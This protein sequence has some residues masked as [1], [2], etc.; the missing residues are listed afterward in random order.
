MRQRVTIM[1]RRETML[2]EENWME[3]IMGEKCM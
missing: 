1:K 2:N 3:L